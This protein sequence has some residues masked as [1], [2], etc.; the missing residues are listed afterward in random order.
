MKSGIVILILLILTACGS[1]PAA[2]DPTQPATPPISL[3]STPTSAT[4]PDEAVIA[5]VNGVGI[6]R[7]KFERAL[8]RSQRDSAIADQ[9]ALERAVLETLIEQE[10]IN[11]G[12]AKLGIVVTEAQIDQNVQ[13]MITQAGSEGAWQAWMDQNLYTE[14]EYR[15]AARE[16]LLTAQVVEQVIGQTIVTPEAGVT[17]VRAR[18]ILVATESQARDLLARLESGESFESLALQFS[19]DVTTRESGGDLGFF[20]REDLTTPELADVAFSLQP[21]EI[22]GPI[23]TDLGYHILQT[24][25][26]GSA[27]TALSPESMAERH[28][29]LFNA[30]LAEEFAG[31]VI[32]RYLN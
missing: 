14:S 10:V 27:E 13:E 21:N 16:Q 1:A 12:A 9:N 23:A 2:V 11:Q 6:P 20:V 4:N 17:Q 29:T 28:A 19:R 22:A 7:V 24:L 15:E 18:H 32:E 8:A 31:A 3:N 5:R 30:W 25:E 26:F